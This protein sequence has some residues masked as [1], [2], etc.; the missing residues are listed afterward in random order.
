MQETVGAWL[1]A[2]GGARHLC[3]AELGKGAGDRLEGVPEALEHCRSH[4]RPSTA[5]MSCGT[6]HTSQGAAAAASSRDARTQSGRR[7]VWLREAAHR[8]G[9][10]LLLLK[11]ELDGDKAATRRQVKPPVQKSPSKHFE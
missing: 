2:P 9:P 7:A 6:S 8:E 10:G 5:M 1:T 4:T 11:Q 3:R